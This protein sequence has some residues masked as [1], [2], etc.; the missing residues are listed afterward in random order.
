MDDR[1]PKVLHVACAADQQYLVH[2]A[3]MLHSV[4]SHSP[5]HSVHIHYMHGP[6]LPREAIRRLTEMTEIN[7]GSISFLPVP[8]GTVAELPETAEISAT[9]WCRIFLPE[10]LPEVERVLYLDID[11]LALDSIAPLWKADL[12]DHYVA[13]VS[14]VWPPWIVGHQERIGLPA[15]Q[16]YFNSGVLLMNLELMR[17]D[18]CTSSIQ[19]HAID[20]REQLVYPDQD[21]LNIVLGSR[22]LSLHPRWNCMNSVLQF[23]G[24]VDVFGSAE[25]AEAR[26]APAIRHFEGPSVNKPWHVLCQARDREAYRRHRRHTPWPR[27]LPDGLTPRNVLTRTA[28]AFRPQPTL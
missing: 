28:R 27:Y 2:S 6:E 12:S 7:G 5:E 16:S 25:V 23:S 14:N 8:D 24:A 3:V 11:T 17:R 19:R 1:V 26:R 13:A 10:L 20:H 18:Q 4:L 22:R 9:M 21:A 15:S